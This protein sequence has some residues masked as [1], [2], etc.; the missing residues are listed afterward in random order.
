MAFLELKNIGK[1]YSSPNSVAVGIRGV[2]LAF[3]KGEFVA[4]TGA[5]GSGK[6][7]LLNVISG[8]D[9]YEEGE[10]LIEDNPTSHYLQ[11]DWEEYR[12]KYISFIF[13]DYNIIESFTVLQNVEL[14]LMH[15]SNK[16]ERRARAIELLTRVGMGDFLNSR[17]SK[18]SGGQK[19]RTVIARA[20]A[21]DSPVI[22]ADEPT[23]NLDSKTSEEIIKLLCEVS[24]DKL[25]IMVTHSFE[26]VEHC[27]TRHVRVFD[28]A[29][30]FDRAT[31]ID[32]DDVAEESPSA[33][34]GAEESKSDGASGAEIAGADSESAGGNGRGGKRGAARRREIKN[35]LKNGVT[36]GKT[37]F[38]ATPK[39]TVFLC[40][41]LILGIIAIFVITSFCGDAFAL[42][43]HRYMFEHID[44]RVVV[45]RKDGN[46]ISESEAA[47]LAEKYGAEYE[48]RYDVLMDEYNQVMAYVGDGSYY[49]YEN[50]IYVSCK[51]VCRES[52]GTDIVGRYPE[53]DSEVLLYLPISH[54]PVFG[55]SAVAVETVTWNGMVFDVSGVKYFYDNTKTPKILFTE[56][57]FSAAT[58]Y[59]YLGY[60]AHQRNIDVSAAF[61]TIRYNAFVP[62]FDIDPFKIYFSDIGSDFDE[63]SRV[64]FSSSCSSLIYGDWYEGGGEYLFNAELSGEVFESREPRDVKYIAPYN[65]IKVFMGIGLLKGIAEPELSSKYMQMSLFFSDDGAAGAAAKRMSDDGYVAVPSYTSYEPSALDAI[66]YAVEG[67]SMLILWIG[68]ILFL[69]FF[70][71][72]CTRRAMDAFKNDMAIMRSMG[73]S[74]RVIRASMYTRMLLSL[75][76]AL[77]VLLVGALVIFLTPQFNPAF[78]FLHAWQYVLIIL[79]MIALTLRVTY[80]QIRRLFKTSVKKSLKGETK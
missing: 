6:S 30:S 57:G 70:L 64:N 12:E 20:L 68:F 24:R 1:I 2:N 62:S 39:L 42:F 48:F 40:A 7:T 79:G 19:Q 22:L 18:L 73:I 36:L 76:P 54:R 50:F 55:K 15:I 41:L 75:V 61:G 31:G 66:T 71:G 28:G 56:N 52:F 80:H 34:S 32:H 10:L 11:P 46:V 69:A 45:T 65:N 21:K 60:R 35:T 43:E 27:A 37:I 25:L 72:L 9:T 14:A 67:V 16:K 26:Q 3:D 13:Q 49:D 51:A 29:V 44:G 4:V 53:K 23:G 38:C 63:D 8:M 58:Y 47:E 74:V 77:F 17:G 5:S 59:R 33:E 78:M